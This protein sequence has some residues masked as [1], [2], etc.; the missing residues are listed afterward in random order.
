MGWRMK[1]KRYVHLPESVN[2][3]LLEKNSIDRCNSV[4]DL[5]IGISSCTVRYSL[6]SMA[7]VLIEMQ[8][9]DTNRQCN[10]RRLPW[11]SD[12]LRNADSPQ[13]L[14]EARNG[15]SPR[16]FGGTLTCQQLDFRLLPPEVW[17]NKCLLFSA[18]QFEVIGKSRHRKLIQR[19]LWGAFFKFN[20]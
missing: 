14:E 19:Y 10:Q 8:K 9:S 3:T 6:N 11:C 20:Y 1:P 7:S 4:K 16:V 5:E 15:T 2:F 18:A 13:K 12:K 17:E